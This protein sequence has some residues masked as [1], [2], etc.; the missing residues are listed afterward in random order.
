VGRGIRTGS[1]IP[2]IDVGPLVGRSGDVEATAASIDDACRRHGFFVVVGHGVDPA[3]TR[4]LVA[5][6]REFFARPEPEKAE[7]AMARGGRAWRGWF[8]V[9]GELTSGS[10][11]R[12]EGLYFGAELPHDDARVL[13]KVPLHGPNLFPVRPAGLRAAVLDHLAAMTS[14]GHALV[15]GLGLGLG[16]GPNWFADH[17]TRD[18]VVL[19]RIFHYPPAPPSDDGWGVGEHTDYGLLTILG[20][21]GLGGLEVHTPD[22]W[23]EAPPVE[24]SFVCNLGDM[25][26]RMTGGRYRSTPHRV[27]N[28]T[29]RSRISF[30][31][32]FDPSWDAEVRPLPLA[33]GEA[34][35]VAR[36]PRWDGGDP[37]GFEGTYG[38]YL[39]AKVVKVFPLLGEEV[40]GDERE[41]T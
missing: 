19:F 37:L 32:F 7:I 10:P 17:L 25:L 35:T 14:L 3:A 38:D 29:G 20:Q 23:I 24:G 30:P 2:V 13:A 11:D 6:A 22:G 39:L 40:L 33:G 31:V 34:T 1:A 27:R 8:P 9:G 12:K 41:T 28:R 15:A 18:P 16:L 36:R 21:D 26:E 5:S 4:R